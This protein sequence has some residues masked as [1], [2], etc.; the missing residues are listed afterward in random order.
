[1][2]QISSDVKY[3]W[4]RGQ[5]YQVVLGSV[6]LESGF[7]NAYCGDYQHLGNPQCFSFDEIEDVE[8]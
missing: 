6:N 7:L 2:R 8:Y 4:V 1:M 3:V 5:K